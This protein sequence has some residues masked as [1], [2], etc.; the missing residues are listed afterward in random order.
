LNEPGHTKVIE[1]TT[2]TT[3]VTS[4]SIVNEEVHLVEGNSNK[5]VNKTIVEV[6]GAEAKDEHK[7]R[8]RSSS[9]SSSSSDDESNKKEEIIEALNNDP[10]MVEIA[11]NT[12]TTDECIIVSEESEKD[13]AL[14][15]IPVPETKSREQEKADSS[16]SSSSSDD[17]SEKEVEKPKSDNEIAVEISSIEK[18]GVKEQD[19][20]IPKEIEEDNEEEVESK[21]KASLIQAEVKVVPESDDL[22]ERNAAS[23]SSSSSSSDNEEEESTNMD[24][25]NVGETEVPSVLVVDEDCPKTNTIEEEEVPITVTENN[26]ADPGRFALIS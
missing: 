15:P 22:Q 4:T 1:E 14:D 6:K 3:Y 10:P 18:E 8:S 16:S 26:E 5:K 23:S 7:S 19:I 20:E 25:A 11:H 2:K 17:E 21:R 24:S 13:V 12:Q 9:S